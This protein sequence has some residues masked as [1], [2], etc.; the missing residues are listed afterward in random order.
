MRVAHGRTD[1][2]A[3]PASPKKL[4]QMAFA[5]C[6]SLPAALRSWWSFEEVGSGLRQPE[7]VDVDVG[8]FVVEGDQAG[9]GL[10]LAGR[11]VVGP[12]K[13]LVALAHRV[14]GSR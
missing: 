3:A 12:R 8:L 4:A 14:T 7:A 5:T 9:D 2:A 10:Q 6:A 11:V 1:G 13:V